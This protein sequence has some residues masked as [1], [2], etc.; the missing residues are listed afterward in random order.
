MSQLDPVLTTLSDMKTIDRMVYDVKTT[1]P[2]HDYIVIATATN[3]RQLQA[4]M[5][6]LKDLPVDSTST[7]HVEGAN[8]SDWVLVTCGDTIVHVFLKEEREYYHLEKLW[9]DLPHWT[10]ADES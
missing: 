3:Q 9:F 7:N 2:F 1:N 8:D 6:R 4:T 5:K 10:V